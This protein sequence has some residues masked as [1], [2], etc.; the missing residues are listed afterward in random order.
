MNH[1]QN[2][3][4]I[5]G[6]IPSGI[7][8]LT[9]GGGQNATGMLAS[10]VMQ[11][12]FKPPMISVAVNLSRYICDWL[13]EDRPFVLNMLAN[14][15]KNFFTH[16][17]RGFAPDEPAFEGIDITYCPRGVPILNDAVGHMECEAVRSIDSDDHRIFLARVVRGAIAHDL[18]PMV[19]VR[20]NGAR[21]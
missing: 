11:A 6:R 13:T 7:Y 17:G 1:Q 18:P 20:K 10:W 21:Y 8:V 16:F 12:G 5:L 19:H 3:N 4:A 15:Q 2:V 14:G 9:V